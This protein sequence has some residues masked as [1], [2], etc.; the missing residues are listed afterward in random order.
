MSLITRCPACET[1]FKVVPDQLK[2]AQGWVRCGHCAEV[3]DAQ[4][5]WQSDSKAESA[6]VPANIQS[7]ASG[8]LA[9]VIASGTRSTDA[10]IAAADLLTDPAPVS[11]APRTVPRWIAEAAQNAG[12]P[13]RIDGDEPQK[14]RPDPGPS[15]GN[16]EGAADF[17]PGAWKAAKQ[18][19]WLAQ[20]SV[21]PS[22][23]SRS[24]CTAA[25]PT[26]PAGLTR[27]AAD[28]FSSSVPSM[29]LP[30]SRAADHPDGDSAH[31]AR[32]D[33][34]GQVT[35]QDESEDESYISYD[36]EDSEHPAD[37]EEKADAAPTAQGLGPGELSFVRDA[38]RGDFWRQRRIR[39]GLALLALVLAV[40]LVLQGLAHYRDELA[41]LN[42]RATPTLNALCQIAG[43]VISPV[44]RIDALVIDS[45][46]FNKSGSDTYRLGFVLKS[47]APFAL[48]VPSI[49][50]TLTNAQNEAVVRRVVSP[51]Q[52]GVT[53]ATVGPRAEVAGSLSL[54]VV[55]EADR[56]ASSPATGASTG[57]TGAP[58]SVAGYRVLAFYP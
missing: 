39:A 34:P 11:A 12:E 57:S 49:E 56:A 2:I 15:W 54:R 37:Q 8:E 46:T 58:L 19:R 52:F 1:M 40:A 55:P 4:H 10:A 5:H 7:P 28:D 53:V 33:I 43:C 23:V 16:G 25:A 21:A 26:A 31:Q 32:P 47:T 30:V 29:S 6:L 22:P 36:F 48:R 35:R 45:S 50:V 3:F 27:P 24:T 51:A 17:D 41:A 20:Q 44:R 13:A 14:S 9:T 18:K 42:P 38:R